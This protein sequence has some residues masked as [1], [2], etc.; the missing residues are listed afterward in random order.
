M[1]RLLDGI[2]KAHWDAGDYWRMRLHPLPFA[3]EDVEL[4][5]MGIANRNNRDTIAA[6]HPR[7][8]G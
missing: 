6:C 3:A 1:F 2:M 7:A 4:I 5:H 8:D